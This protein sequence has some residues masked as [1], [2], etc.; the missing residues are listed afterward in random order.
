MSYI[1]YL[2]EFNRWLESNELSNTAQLLYFK[3][4]IIF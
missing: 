1:V 2:N 3:M 4:T